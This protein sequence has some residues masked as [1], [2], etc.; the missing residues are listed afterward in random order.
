VHLTRALIVL[1]KIL[2]LTNMTQKFELINFWR[3]DYEA[4]SVAVVDII[5]EGQFCAS[6][7]LTIKDWETDDESLNV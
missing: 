5:S 6:G 7:N 4:P 2:N 3:G 1:R